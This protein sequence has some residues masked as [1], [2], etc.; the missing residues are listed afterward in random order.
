MSGY[1]IGCV[2]VGDLST[3]CYVVKNKET[4]DAC[5]IDPGD[6]LTLI[7]DLLHRMEAKCRVILT[8]FWQWAICAVIALPFASTKRMPIC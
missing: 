6:N 5:V 3:N 7:Q 2:A 1:E 4:G 8:I